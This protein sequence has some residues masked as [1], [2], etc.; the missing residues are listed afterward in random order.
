M[1]NEITDLDKQIA[2]LTARK[3]ALLN[4]RRQEAL[5]EVKA[6]IAQYSFTAGELSLLPG[7]GK[8][9][10]AKAPAKYAHPNNPA[11]TWAG[12]KGPR[13]KWV[14]NHLA[15]GGQLDDLLIVK[16]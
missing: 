1:S 14:K 10:V 3:Q 11:I 16:P 6:L 12:G 7:K 2:E 8:P 5:Q 13:P 4:S 15:G 9:A